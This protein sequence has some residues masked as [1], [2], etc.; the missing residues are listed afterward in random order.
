MT[1]K[2]VNVTCIRCT[3]PLFA[4]EQR[5]DGKRAIHSFGANVMLNPDTPTVAIAVCLSCG[6]ETQFDR[7]LLPPSS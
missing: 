2:I 5:A 3:K 6:A 7:E 1:P 4:F